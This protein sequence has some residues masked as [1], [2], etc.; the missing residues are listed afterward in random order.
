LAVKMAAAG[1]LLLALFRHSFLALENITSC[2]KV[3]YGVHRTA[4]ASGT[5]L[6][7]SLLID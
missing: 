5:H 3:N 2:P 4:A 1:A 7:R 6:A